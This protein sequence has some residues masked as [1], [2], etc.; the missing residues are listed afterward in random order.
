MWRMTRADGMRTHATIGVHE[1]TAAV[2]WFFNDRPLGSR[3]FEDLGDALRWCDQLE[4]QNW[5]VGWRRVQDADR[6]PSSFGER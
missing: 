4:S 1:G 2:T 3:A 6:A 5:S